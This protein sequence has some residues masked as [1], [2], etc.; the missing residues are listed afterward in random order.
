MQ[1]YDEIDGR[2]D[3]GQYLQSQLGLRTLKARL[4][5]SSVEILAREVIRRMAAHVPDLPAESADDEDLEALCNALL[6]EDDHAGARFIQDLRTDGTSVQEVYLLYLA[7]SARMLGDWWND[8]RISFTDVALG[9]SRM[10][11]IMR[12]LRYQFNGPQTE[13]KRC[14]VFASVPGETHVLG[15]R[16]AADLFRKKG[17]EIDL[18][19]DKSHDQLVDELSQSDATVVGLS[20]GGEKSI[21]PLSKLII[22]LRISNPKLFIFVSGNIVDEA[23]DA[24][25]L[26]D[27]DGVMTD[28]E[29]AMRIMSSVWDGAIPPP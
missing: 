13:S 6:S 18:K 12:A 9:T 17:W 10:Y 5:E 23:R 1:D 29:E 14:A 4:P 24:V 21:E 3:S 7:R 28:V 16:M 25:D 27:A 8:S 11:A 15:V 26:M 22:A 19:I 2:F 20:A